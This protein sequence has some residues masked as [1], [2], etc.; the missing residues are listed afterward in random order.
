MTSRRGLDALSDGSEGRRPTR[1]GSVIGAA[2]LLV[3]LV[4]SG[5]PTPRGVSHPRPQAFDPS[6]AEQAL[7][8]KLQRLA[9]R[10]AVAARAA[11]LRDL[12]W[13]RWAYRGD[14]PGALDLLRRAR[15]ASGNLLAPWVLAGLAAWSDLRLAVGTAAD[16]WEQVLGAIA[17]IGQSPRQR[18]DP[19]PG[20]SLVSLSHLATRR[21]LSTT[22][23]LAEPWPIE[24]L[25]R[26]YRLEL[27]ARDRGLVARAI[28]RRY[29]LEGRRREALVW[30]AHAGCPRRVRLSA[31]IGRWPRIDLSRPGRA[32]AGK[33]RLGRP[34]NLVDCRLSV[35]SPDGRPG[36]RVVQAW[37]P[38]A[39]GRSRGLLR[40]E[41]SGPLVIQVGGRP[42]VDSGREPAPRPR[43]RFVPVRIPSGG[44]RVRLRIPVSA[45]PRALRLQLLSA[46]GPRLGAGSERSG[47]APS[48]LAGRA[49]QIYAP[50]AALLEMQDAL[51]R[52]LPDAGRASAK[53]LAL[54]APRF[55]WGLMGRARLESADSLVSRDIARTRAKAILG[56]ALRDDPGLLRARVWMAALLRE[57]GKS[58][59]ALRLLAMGSRK[60]RS[61]ASPSLPGAS[62]DGRRLAAYARIALYVDLRWRALARREISRL[63][64]RYPRWTEAARLRLRLARGE[65][66]LATAPAAAALHRLDATSRAWARL[67][68]RQGRFEQARQEARRLATLRGDSSVLL[69]ER[70]RWLRRQGRTVA[71]LPLLRRHLRAGPW[72]STRRLALVDGLVALG[73]RRDA[74][75]VLRAGRDVFTEQKDLR[76]ALGALGDPSLVSALRVSGD[77]AVKRY[78]RAR[79][80]PGK[81]PVYVLDRTAVRVLPGGGRL[82]LT[83]QIVHL[84]TKEAVRRF[85]EVRL[86]VGA[87]VLA[88]R[89][90]KP[91]GSTREPEDWGG[92]RTVSL[93]GLEVGDLIE[94]EY[95]I[96]LPRGSAWRPGGFLEGRFRFRSTVAHF[97]RSELVVVAPSGLRLRFRVWGRAPR[98]ERTRLGRL[99]V[100]TLRAERV[101]RLAP[102]PLMGSLLGPLPTVQVGARVSLT[103]L[104]RQRKELLWGLDTPSFEVRSLARRL[105]G[106]RGTALA[107]VRRLLRWVQANIRESGGLYVSAAHTLARR[108]GSRLQLL[109]ALLGVCRLGPVETLLARPRS[110]EAAPVGAVGTGATAVRGDLPALGFFTQA[111][112]R[113]KLP[114]GPL[115]LLPQLQQAPVGYLPPALAGAQV[116][117]VDR[118]GAAPWR[119]PLDA[120]AEARQSRIDVQLRA[121]GSAVIRGQEQIRGVLALRLRAALRRVPMRR[122]R[123]YLERA[124]FLRSFAG[125][126]LETLQFEHAKEPDRSLVMRYRVRVPQLAR[127]DKAGLRL[128]VALFASRLSRQLARLPARRLSL[129]AGPVGP[130][131]LSATIHLPAGFRA[132]G[133]FRSVALTEPYGRYG[134]RVTR[135]L[136]GAP[137]VHIERL[138]ILPYQVIAPKSYAGFSQFCADVDRVEAGE[139]LLVKP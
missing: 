60:N 24:R 29:R 44:L 101:T 15:K 120:A 12:G 33:A 3:S 18:L 128:P 16:R 105:C 79:W 66:A 30:E 92:K 39:P 74:L 61:V 122:L 118:P 23:R 83:H 123:P 94:L 27:P 19:P 41:W 45:S 46:R 100:V 38:A 4:G 130:H 14:S 134:Q 98:V 110:T 47:G 52:G 108:A 8:A 20:L 21:L 107:R 48:A 129:Q 91:D 87:R 86:P 81:R 96:G 49:R 126:S 102:E 42:L 22:H 127:P 34:R 99:Q 55:P 84:R 119:L 131:R 51:A 67:L 90:R 57:Q 76:E 89:T 111:L 139:I 50:L 2:M 133:P 25:V 9:A 114:S 17:R 69:A 109:R 31:R 115:Y 112:L 6:A 37:W 54:R 103:E 80:G 72:D 132:R 113:L 13:L 77:A 63:V 78:R 28:A 138:L 104:M 93:P 1:Q 59:Q 7:R 125:A 26:L 124:F 88:L 71:A 5:C 36:V 62:S 137:V 68:G 97:F 82:V 32:S 53:R 75:R 10:H 106:A 65:D 121:D 35:R 56:R 70:A 116:A 43:V 58:H 73:R 117:S 135:A 136:S 64:R 95:V 11:V 40:V 85:G